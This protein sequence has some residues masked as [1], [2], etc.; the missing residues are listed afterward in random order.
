MKSNDDTLR[1]KLGTAI[2]PADAH[3]IDIQYHLKCWS[4]HVSNVLRKSDLCTDNNSNISDE[5]AAEI[6]FT[7]LLK[8]SLKQGQILSMSSLQ[9]MYIN[10]RSANNVPNPNCSRRKLKSLIED[11]VDGYEFHPPIRKNESERVSVKCARDAAIQLAESIQTHRVDLDVKTVFDA[12]IILRK[13]IAR[14]D[15][16]DFTGSLNDVSDKHIPK[17][18]YCFFRWM[19]QGPE[20]SLASEGKNAAVSQN[21]KNLA[22]TTIYLSLSNRQMKNSFDSIWNSKDV[23]QQL[24][25]G[26]AVSQQMRSKKMVHLLNGFGVSVDYTRLLKLEAQIA[27]SVL[28]RMAL[29]GEVYTPRSLNPGE[30][31]FF[32][33]DN[34]DFSEDTPDGKHTL[35][36]TTISIYQKCKDNEKVPPLKLT[37]ATNAK[38]LELT[39]IPRSFTTLLPCKL[40][41]NA[42]PPSPEHPLFGLNLQMPLYDLLQWYSTWLMSKVM[43]RNIINGEPN[44]NSEVDEGQVK[45]V[46]ELPSWAAYNSL[47]SKEL[48]ITHVEMLPMIAAPTH[49]WST[50]L[51]VLK[52][53]HNITIKVMGLNQKTVVTLDMGYS[54]LQSYSI[55]SYIEGSGIDS[56]WIESDV[57]GS[58][59]V[60]Q[61]LDGKHVKRGVNAHMVTLQAFF[62]LYTE[63]FFSAHPGSQ[64][65][66]IEAAQLLNS[67]CADADITAIQE[68][69]D[70]IASI[71]EEEHVFQQMQ[72]YYEQT[73]PM[74]QFTM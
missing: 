17:E 29:D 3:A 20:T 9:D 51:T 54:N 19:L 58:A 30:H 21:A 10:I 64:D 6:E 66:Y 38:S 42:K 60:K 34:S 11:N 40:P 61:I 16:W 52:L 70:T 33:I 27:N 25:V 71:I 73:R 65:R 55:G 44:H 36:C 48:P 22:Q 74:Y 63:A 8:E 26:I 24:A 13:V 45:T 4:K 28:E 14:S 15:K 39:A 32:A 37:H 72:Q 1:V 47:V 43:V 62:Q 35:H 46:M 2:D 67:A 56:V 68:A 50:L 31:I 18:L 41:K 69:H 57:Y 7:S 5:I 53:S 23:P 12:A 59:T 49:E